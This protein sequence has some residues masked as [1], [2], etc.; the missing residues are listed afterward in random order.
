MEKYKLIHI[1]KHLT[2][3]KDG[4]KESEQVTMSSSVLKQKMFFKKGAKY[5]KFK[6]HKQF[7][8]KFK[9]DKNQ[10]NKFSKP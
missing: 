9:T 4:N 2:V 10:R 7:T 8:T 3:V 1:E 5:R 6:Q